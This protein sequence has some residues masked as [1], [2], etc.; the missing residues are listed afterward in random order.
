[1]NNL[2]AFGIDILR[3]GLMLGAL[4]FVHELGHFFV[5]KRLGVPVLEFGFGFPPRLWRFWKNHGWIEIQSRRIFIPRDFKLPENLSGGAL[6]RYKTKPEANRQVLTEIRVVDPQSEEAPFASPVQDMDRGTE[7]TLNWIPLGGF[8]RLLGEE[9]PNIP[10]GFGKAKPAVRVA[11][12]LAG[13]TMNFILAF[14]VFALTAIAAPPYVEVQTTRLAS[15]SPD[16]PASL[17]GLRPGDIIVSVNGQNVRDDF[18]TM[19]QLLRD[20]AGKSVVLTVQRGA[21]T[22][23]GIS[24]VP[25]VNPPAGQGPV[26]I[27]LNVWV[28]LR[29]SGVEPGSVADS[30]GVRAGDV[31]VFIVDPKGR[32]LRDQNELLEYTRAHP[33]WKIEWHLSRNNKLLDPITIQIPE[34]LDAK[35]AS[36]GLNLQLSLLDAPR[37]GVEQIL[38]IAT[39]IPKM[40][41]QMVRG[42]APPNSVVG[43]VG[44]YQAT[45]EVAR[46]GGELAVVRLLGALSLSLAIFNLFPFPPLDGGQLLYVILEWLRGGKRIDLQKQGMVN[47]IGAAVLI[48]FMIIVS[49]FDVQRLLSGQPI[50][51]P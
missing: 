1:M 38:Q 30:A 25:R 11:I 51:P 49:F 15:V 2:L 5:A 33:G 40:L 29:V 14:L 16:S 44:I 18:P 23:D 45:G 20:N 48:S 4:I 37:A 27:A 9:D 6:V 13:V 39:A 21:Q 3:F 41:T 7:Y 32:P 46:L 26:G 10:G 8:V 19:S 12:L 35:T 24:L 28:G 31:L 50:L 17:A 36:L 43:I 47:L 42:S 34:T 22:L